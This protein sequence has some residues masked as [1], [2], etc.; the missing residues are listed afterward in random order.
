MNPKAQS[1]APSVKK[2]MDEF[3]GTGKPP[4]P[5]SMEEPRT[6]T[7]IQARITW[8]NNYK[9]LREDLEAKINR[10]I[11][12]ARIEELK[13]LKQY[14]SFN[15]AYTTD[16]RC[17]TLVDIRIEELSNNLSKGDGDEANGA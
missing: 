1:E 14:D 17:A 4:Y 2:L 8:E 13:H 12:E 10:L 7:E 6:A 9:R 11:V 15:K 5:L 16:T 3:F